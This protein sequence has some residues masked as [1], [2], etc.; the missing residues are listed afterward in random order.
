[1]GLLMGPGP[2]DL[3]PAQGYRRVG[4]L[5]REEWSRPNTFGIVRM[6]S[7]AIVALGYL[8]PVTLVD[9]FLTRSQLRDPATRDALG[10][11]V[12][13]RTIGVWREALY[14]ARIFFYVLVLNA[15]LWSLAPVLALT[16]LLVVDTVR[17]AI[18]GVLVWGHLSIAT[19]R[20]ILWS[21]VNI[22]ELVL[23]FAIF[24]LA[25]GNLLETAT[26]SDAIWISASLA[27]VGPSCDLLGAGPPWLIGCQRA[28]T[29]LFGGLVLGGLMGRLGGSSRL[30]NPETGSHDGVSTKR[31]LDE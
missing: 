20:S 21:F 31:Q 23:A 8:S 1:M 30:Y 9:W 27:G 19:P 10:P 7:L 17:S 14:V 28:V 11:R 13:A 18:G 12:D 25:A 3:I 2:R 4:E 5:L 15:S 24:Y 26:A 22:L 6:L 29:Y 16:V